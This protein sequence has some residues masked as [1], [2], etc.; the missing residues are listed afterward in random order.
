MKKTFIE[1]SYYLGL[2]NINN[3]EETDGRN[4]R[5]RMLSLSIGYYFK[6]TAH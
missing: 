2:A 4:I 6:Q 1:T 3:Q 5:H